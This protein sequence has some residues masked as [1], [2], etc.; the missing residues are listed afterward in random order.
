MTENYIFDA[1]NYLLG[2]CI[3]EFSVGVNVV[4]GLTLPGIKS[5]VKLHCLHLW[6]ENSSSGKHG[7]KTSEKKR[8]TV[9]ADVWNDGVVGHVACLLCFS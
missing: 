8:P 2:A 5:R 3:L 9:S 4:S 1:T 7:P 6:N